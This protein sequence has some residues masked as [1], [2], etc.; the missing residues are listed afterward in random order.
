MGKV[1][2]MRVPDF[3]KDGK[4]AFERKFINKPLEPVAGKVYDY[5][6]QVY[7]EKYGMFVLGPQFRDLFANLTHFGCVLSLVVD[8]HDK[9]WMKE[10]YHLENEETLMRFKRGVDDALLREMATLSLTTDK[11]WFTS[12]NRKDLDP[13]LGKWNELLDLVPNLHNIE[14]EG[15]DVMTDKY[16]LDLQAT[17]MTIWD[18]IDR[19]ATQSREVYINGVIQIVK[20]S[21]ITPSN[22]LY[23]DIYACLRLGE[24]ISEEQL[25]LHDSSTSR[26]VRENY[27]KAKYTRL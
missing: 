15:E 22:A 27:I 18:G 7:K 5:L 6:I 23:R 21:G 8:I 26:Y 17:L 19:L 10:H 20:D 1:R 13:I 9:D 11:I 12:A 14:Y 25:R 3:K 24:L 2:A 4:E 16:I